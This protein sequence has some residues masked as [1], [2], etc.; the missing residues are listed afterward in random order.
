MTDNA[1]QHIIHYSTHTRSHNNIHTPQPQ[2]MPLAPPHHNYVTTPHHDITPHP[3]T[4][5]PIHHTI[6]DYLLFI[7]AWV[8]QSLLVPAN[9]AIPLEGDSHKTNISPDIRL[10][11][12]V[13]MSHMGRHVATHRCSEDHFHVT[14]LRGRCVHVSSDIARVRDQWC[15]VANSR[16]AHNYYRYECSSLD[17]CYIR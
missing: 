16:T 13:L 11:C 6:N 9:I 10:W 5:I 7:M 14:S 12:M 3:T 8:S 2:T 15:G 4:H 1:P 17:W